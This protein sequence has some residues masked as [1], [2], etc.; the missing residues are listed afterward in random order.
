[1]SKVHNLRC[2]VDDCLFYIPISEKAP[3]M[4]IVAANDLKIHLRQHT[5]DQ[6]L[7]TIYAYAIHNLQ[8]DL[9]AAQ[10]H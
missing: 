1:M 2:P 7:Q 8:H 9:Q 4:E 6:L 10:N 5:L 3:K